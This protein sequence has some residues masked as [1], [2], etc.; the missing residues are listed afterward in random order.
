[1]G[2]EPTEAS[3]P[4]DER[5]AVFQAVLKKVLREEEIA[6]QIERT[7]G[8]ESEDLEAQANHSADKLWAPA[9]GAQQYIETMA[10]Q[11][12]RLR[13]RLRR[14][15]VHAG[16]E[17][18]AHPFL[19]AA[20]AIAGLLLVVSSFASDLLPGGDASGWSRILYV[21]GASLLVLALLVTITAYARTRRGGP[22]GSVAPPMLLT[23]TGLAAAALGIVEANR[24]VQFRTEAWV[25]FSAILLADA[26]IVAVRIYRNVT[27]TNVQG[28]V[29]AQQAAAAAGAAPRN[30]WLE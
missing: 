5:R 17:L 18:I 12:D 7:P 23:L 3:G 30:P 26:T 8:K 10:D 4:V 24:L 21:A 9:V 2:G 11:L 29:A 27:T 15:V 16:H 22:R 6:T 20:A 13:W 14:P 19:Q 1:M 28:T 25:A